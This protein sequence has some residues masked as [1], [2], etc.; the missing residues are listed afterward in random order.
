[1]DSLKRKI[2]A[3]RIWKYSSG[4]ADSLMNKRLA[5]LN[6][7]DHVCMT[8]ASG[9]IVEGIV[10]DN[11]G[12]NS[13]SVQITS[14]ITMRYDQI[15]F[16]SLV[17]PSATGL[18][19]AQVIQ[20]DDSSAG[21]TP[22]E[23]PQM[24]EER[25]VECNRESVSRAFKA[26][27]NDEKKCLTQANNKLQSYFQSH[28][29]SKCDEAISLIWHAIREHNWDYHPGVSLYFA[30]VQMIRGKVSDAA[31][32]FYY[33]DDVRSAYRA[34]YQG[35][36]DAGDKKLYRL[37]AAFAAIYLCVG[38][39][40]Y[41][42]EAAE[43]LV[44]SSSAAADVSGVEYALNQ[45]SS[46]EVLSLLENRVRKVAADYIENISRLH[47]LYKI[48]YELRHSM[49][50]VEIKKAIDQYLSNKAQNEEPG[51]GTVPTGN[52][53]GQNTGGTQG[54]GDTPDSEPDP[55]RD[56]EGKIVAYKPFEDRGTMEAPDGTKYFFDIKDVTD[57]ELK[58]LLKKLSYKNFNPI[59]AVFRLVK[60]YGKYCAV[61][62]KRASRTSPPA[63]D[64]SIAAASTLY[65]KGKITEA[66]EIYK[67]HIE[68]NDFETAFSQIVLCCNALIKDKADPVYVREL[69]KYIQAYAGRADSYPKALEALTQYYTK[70]QN[71]SEAVRTHDKILGLCAPDE[72][73]RILHNLWSKARCYR[74]MG[75]DASAISELLD[76]LDIVK[77][78]K[79]KDRHP[80]RDS[81]VYIE[82][83]ELY[84]D[85]DD[86][87][88]AE[89]YARLSATEDR[90]E[91]LMQRINARKG[92]PAPEAQPNDEDDMDDEEENPMDEVI[93]EPEESLQ[94]AYGLYADQA[95]FDA[96][97]KNDVS[98]LNTALNFKPGQLY[99]LLTYLH[100]AALLSEKS[101]MTRTADD[102]GTVYVGHVIKT[103]SDAFAYAFNSPL[104]Q[105]DYLSTELLAT[106]DEA[107]K[108][109]PSLCPDLFAAAAL[110]A[111]FE[112]PSVPD[113]S[114]G[115]ISDAAQ[116][117]GYSR[118]PSLLPLMDS[119]KDFREKTGAGMDSFAAYKTSDK[120]ISSIIAEAKEC[121]NAADLRNDVYESQGQVRRMREYLFTGNDSELRRCL[122]IVA[123][124]DT[125]K[126]PYV[127][128][129]ITELF[130]RSNKPATADN[131]DVKKIDRYIDRFWDQARDVIQN[132]GRHIER[133]HDKVKGSKRSNIVNMIR[134]ILSCICDWLA[135]AEHSGGDGNG[136]ALHLY[137]SSAPQVTEY[138]TDMIRAC[139]EFSSEDEFD[140]GSESIR[141]AAE[142]LLSKI[143]GTYNGRQRKYFFI[144]F[145]RGED[146]LLTDSYLPEIQSSF[147]DMPDFN[148]LRRIV[149]HT[150]HT[151]IPL[152]ERLSEILSNIETK[153][154]FRSARLIMAYGEETGIK[155]ITEHKDISRYGECLKQAKQRFETVYQ[156][157]S[158][159]LSL[160]ESY[161]TISDINGEK[162][163]ILKTA[164]E[165]YRITRLTNDY[166][167]YMRLLETIRSRI[168]QNA[169]KKGEQLLRQLEELADK[170]EYGFGVFTKEM[171]EAKINDQNFSSAE[172]SMSCILRGDVN[173]ISDYSD[174]PFG[175]FRE[176]ISEH[177][178][179]YRAVRGAGKDIANTI[180]DYSGKRDLEKALVYLTN[181]AHKETKGGANLLRSW[182]PRGGPASP[183]QIERL[184]QRLGFKPVSVQPDAGLDDEAYQV[185]CRKQIGKVNFVHQIPAFGSKS[186][187]E[188]FRVLCLY[189]R[190]D[191]DSL[192]DKFREVNTTAK[193]TVVM[194]DFALNVEERRRLARR[195][196]E[197]KSF[198]K[199]FIVI[200]RVIL[201]YLAK[202]YAEN[203]VIKRLMAVTLP[204]AYY[205]PFVES[206]T[207]DMPPELFTGR[208]TE[209]TSIESADGVNLVYGGRQLGKSALL[210]MA[211]HNIDKNG[212]GDRALLADIKKL[213]AAEAAKVVSDKLIIEGI[214]DESCRCDTWTELAGHLQRRLND[215]NPETRINYLLLMLDEADELIRTS[216]NATDSPITAL[217]N[218]PSNRF[219]LVMA[220]LHNL[221][222]YNR[223]M[224]H[225]NSTLIHLNSVVI[226][227]FRRE[228]AT[229]LLTSILAYLG[230]R[231]NQKI[232]DNI[233][234]S[235]Y[236]YPGLIQFYCQKL[237]EAM[238]SEDYAGYS[239]IKTPNY[240][241]NEDHYKRVLS[242]REF[243]EKVN[244]KLEATL[245]TE[246]ADRSNYHAIA[247]MIAYLCYIEPNEKGYTVDSLLK[248]AEAYSVDRITSLTSE[249][250]SEILSEM[251]DLNVITVM[252]GYYRF[253]TD[254]FR[255]LLGSQDKVEEELR[256]YSE[257]GKA[258]C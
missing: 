250:F 80:Y 254:G 77:R 1:M 208:E 122:N 61:S 147:C 239:E 32:S 106:F 186:E 94:N 134:R 200:D 190:F 256:K 184:L 156:D 71:Y 105:S 9:Q 128:E 240:E 258:I 251:W 120:V 161:G 204:F 214:L 162:T 95:G 70:I 125:A 152:H 252:E 99:C 126:Y 121:R 87:D 198:A 15:S 65:A 139:D 19:V 73:G 10:T 35:A 56:Y 54:C 91:T 221:S 171:I 83:A 180:F 211:K 25:K 45:I 215:E 209:L 158:D 115:V 170:P 28:D 72:Y 11:D 27:E 242:D 146:I 34:A 43:V 29:Q 107:E 145:L 69:Q 51:E 48:L 33:G 166:G 238:K 55:N 88:K 53:G 74:L 5:Q 175:Y 217:K 16:L 75:D 234:A 84:F 101:E 109:I 4:N 46:Q 233:L 66:V 201:F 97:E 174:E 47:D 119:L 185:F 79:L 100:S 3:K 151:H 52:N 38:D 110:Y 102:G 41:S 60:R 173:A 223:N 247:L 241:V 228:E 123:D 205:Q 44:N 18:S 68:G 8:H 155:E 141:R 142:E 216:V 113:Y 127:K 20:K 12:K 24:V 255:K 76:W 137:D 243:T 39:G 181:N 157:F 159:E 187:Q 160:Y 169:S 196:K 165:W 96:L 188:G 111:L 225:K 178:T 149:R 218:L 2:A 131:L 17:N 62:V 86:L 140:W 202:H 89:K 57:T 148:I 220:G 13:L 163:A 191:C 81:T 22:E 64:N 92:I 98:I 222:R 82:L 199:T 14:H 167:F 237:L 203:T 193:N 183:E 213:S 108:Y 114:L 253:A 58:N 103:A 143:N 26:L 133:P 194:L 236:N 246:E 153:H 226:K 177:A 231:F 182:I 23:T 197:E 244:E 144:D 206:S 176:F 257:E 138:L 136:Y 118:Y 67:K 117:Y 195:I 235:T 30:N 232:I 248:V 212:N 207:K 40:A 129:N 179:N 21:G 7:G 31:E 224:N 192:M 150:T 135:A 168:S 132:E 42:S 227:Q 49:P 78:N 6:P 112:T 63:K 104:R 249:Q 85:T 154:N 36:S 59:P 230:F 245:F 37:A 93:S 130:I 172:F 116:K 229:K 90:R 189:G 210:K 124:N 50:G 219:K 164:Y